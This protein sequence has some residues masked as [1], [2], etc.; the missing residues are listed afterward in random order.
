M[1]CK[2]LMAVLGVGKVL[3]KVLYQAQL[4]EPLQVLAA[5][6]LLFLVLVQ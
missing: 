6:L 1:K 2:L 3:L 5:E 4:V